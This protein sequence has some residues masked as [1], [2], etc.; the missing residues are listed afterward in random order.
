[1]GE[2]TVQLVDE[3]S[4]HRPLTFK[5]S[6]LRTHEGW[7]L[8]LGAGLALLYFVFLAVSPLLPNS[9]PHVLLGMTA[10]EILVGRAAALALGYSSD[11]S[12]LTVIPVVMLLETILVCIFYPLFVFSY[13]SLLVFN[14][15][16]AMFH[17]VR[18]SAEAHKD[19]VQK[20]GIIGLFFFVWLPFWMTGPVIGCVIG[21]LL[22][23]RTWV[24]I[25]VVLAGTYVAILGWGLFMDEFQERL[26]AYGSYAGVAIVA[27]LVCV[28]LLLQRVHRKINGN[29]NGG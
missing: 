24:N 5:A 27:A 17:R 23:L 12:H 2:Q 22:G 11:L 7:L 3:R 14:R 1:M 15:L 20:Y 26:A 13:N 6:L 18:T 10:T 16:G 29:K 19:R 9:E 8:L 4:S 25:T 21:F 28:F